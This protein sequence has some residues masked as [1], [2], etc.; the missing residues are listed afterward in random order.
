MFFQ[1][2]LLANIYPHIRPFH[3]LSLYPSCIQYPTLVYVLYTVS[4]SYPCILPVYSIQILPL[5]TSCIQYPDPT[6]VYF[7]YTAPYPSIRPVNS[8]LPLYTSCIQYPDPTL[9]Y[10]LYT[11]SYLKNPSCKQYPTLAYVLYT[12][13]RSYACI[14]PVYSTL[15]Q[16]PSCN[17]YPTLVSVIDP[18]P[19]PYIHPLTS[20]FSF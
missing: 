6:L 16:Y 11:A 9:V 15:P 17:Q 13:S 12:V 14:R 3:P 18:V 20:I 7:L 1:P 2:S 8:I 5:Y 19:F 4:R 10:V